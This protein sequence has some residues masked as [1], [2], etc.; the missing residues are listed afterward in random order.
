MFSSHIDIAVNSYFSLASPEAQNMVFRPRG[1]IEHLKARLGI[2][3]LNDPHPQIEGEHA[4][5]N[6]RRLYGIQHLRYQW[7]WAGNQQETKILTPD[8]KHT[9]KR[10]IVVKRVIDIKDFPE[11]RLKRARETQKAVKKETRLRSID[12]AERLEKIADSSER[13]A[14]SSE[15]IED[16]KQ[17][18]YRERVLEKAIR[19][20]ERV[21][22]VAASTEAEEAIQALERVRR[23]AEV[24]ALAEVEKQT[25]ERA[26]EKAVLALERVM[27]ERGAPASRE[28]VAASR[29]AEKAI[30]ALE[31]V[32]K[33]AKVAASAEAEERRADPFSLD[34]LF[35][36]SFFIEVR[37][38]F[39]L[40]SS[41]WI[42]LT[43]HED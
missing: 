33:E 20:L 23:E 19:A 13:I 37:F 25:R 43:L 21:T 8:L 31:N 32:R 7:F 27:M 24:A 29:E 6:F 5:E 4:S 11:S 34:R 15:R 28:E 1:K 26:L 38:D 16:L 30:Q 42:L 14:D 39:P 3:L 17:E 9:V 22:E 12:P 18:Q 10:H 35:N 36:F 41:W 2:Q 40:E